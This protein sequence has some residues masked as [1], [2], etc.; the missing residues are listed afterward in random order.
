MVDI[1]DESTTGIAE[2]DVVWTTGDEDDELLQD[3]QTL[4]AR[5]PFLAGNNK[6]VSYLAY[7]SC[8][9]TVGQSCEL[10]GVTKTSVQRW[11]KEDDVFKR[12]EDEE[13]PNLQANVGPDILKFEFMR[14]M[15]ML[16]KTDMLLIAKG[17][18]NLEGMSAREYEIFKGLRRFYTANE[19]LSLE[20]VMHPEKHSNGPT[21][22]I[23]TWSNRVEVP[24]LESTARELSDGTVY[25][26]SREL[27]DS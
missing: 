9:F 5:I 27:D 21:Q 8:G 26:E 23:L 24:V 15:R 16:L 12:W 7:R 25:A 14:N 4:V 18:S 11:R 13:L 10:A 19:L 1:E 17:M 6:K 2:L 22:V 3:E 20:K